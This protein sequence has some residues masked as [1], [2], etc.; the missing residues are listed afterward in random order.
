VFIG[1]ASRCRIFV[2][3]L[4]VFNLDLSLVSVIFHILVSSS[5]SLSIQI[6][7]VRLEHI[8]FMLCRV[9]CQYSLNAIIFSMT[10]GKHHKT[11]TLDWQ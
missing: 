4:F 6:Y 9:V 10:V 2:S 8:H 7:V 11:L 3:H 1:A 5:L